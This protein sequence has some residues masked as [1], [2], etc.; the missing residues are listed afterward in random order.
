MEKLNDHFSYKIFE[1][2]YFS[3]EGLAG[4]HNAPYNIMPDFPENGEDLCIAVLNYNRVELTIKLLGSI[5]RKLGNFKGEIL[6]ID[7]HSEKNQLARLESFIKTSFLN[8]IVKKQSEN[9]GVGRARNIAAKNTEKKWIMFIDS[10]MFFI[11]NPLLKIKETINSLGVYFLNI[12]IVDYDRESV[13]ALGG[14]L[15][16]SDSK[17][18][19]VAGAG[20]VFNIHGKVSYKDIEFKHPFLSDF[21][22]GGSAVLYR[23]KFIEMGGF[24]HD[25]FIGFEDTDF[26]LRLYSKGI[27]IG[28]IPCFS[29]IHDHKPSTNKEDLAADKERYSNKIIQASGDAFFN[30]HK[31]GIYNQFTLDW[32]SEKQK[33]LKTAKK[34]TSRIELK[35]NNHL[36]LVIDK[37]NWAFHNIANNIEKHLSHKFKIELIFSEDYQNENWVDLYYELYKRKPAIVYFFWRPSLFLFDSVDVAT[38]LRERHKISQ[39][40][41]CEYFNS[42]VLLTSIYDHL[43]LGESYKNAHFGFFKSFIDNYSTSSELLYNIYSNEFPKKPGIVIQDG[44]DLETFIK[45]KES[46]IEEKSKNDLIVGWVGNSAWGIS[47]DGID[48]KGFRTIIKPAIE[49]LKKQGVNIILKYCDSTEPATKI[50]HKEMAGFYNSIDAYLCLSDIEGTPNTILEAMACG[51]AVITT[52]VGIVDEVFGKEQ[53]KFIL[54]SRNIESLSEKLMELYKN[55]NMLNVL[56]EENLIRIQGWSWKDKTELFDIFFSNALKKGAKIKYR[57]HKEIQNDVEKISNEVVNN[58]PVHGIDVAKLLTKNE[59]LGRKLDQLQ[60]WYNKEYEVL[61]LTYKRFGH[62]IKAL[63]G[64]RSFKSLFQKK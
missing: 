5:E 9:H 21:L 19:L 18:G 30:K 27:K 50:P 55:K 63:Q 29:V 41:L 32:L 51:I 23:E 38:G 31:I 24:D 60:D 40:D 11:D 14:A 8:I 34:Y 47:E 28:N 57:V 53:R 10:D 42:T 54:N 4:I 36:I 48:H 12:P 20:S 35:G 37:R 33:E 62:L 6:I 56:G 45:T 1:T 64:K 26:S 3:N 13:F 17:D 46:R 16:M 61:P 2:P 22:F 59:E 52:N 44:I 15:F 43:Y 49:E 7:N 25:M 39:A 58:E